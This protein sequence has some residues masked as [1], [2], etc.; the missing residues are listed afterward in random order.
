MIYIQ[1]VAVLQA[2]TNERDQR[3]SARLVEADWKVIVMQITTH[4]NNDM[5]KS[6]HI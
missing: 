4:Y 6:T 2:E 5:Q 1:G 3:R